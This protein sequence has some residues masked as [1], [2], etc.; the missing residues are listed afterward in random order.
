MSLETVIIESTTSTGITIV[1]I[2]GT[3]TII[4]IIWFL[5][6]FNR[7]VKELTKNDNG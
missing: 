3:A 5:K 6:R 7:K 1:F 2:V 4:N